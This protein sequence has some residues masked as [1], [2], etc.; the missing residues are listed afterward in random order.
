MRGRGSPLTVNGIIVFEGDVVF[1]RADS[2]Y[3]PPDLTT[4]NSLTKLK[5]DYE[6]LYTEL[7]K[8]KPG[9]CAQCCEVDLV[10]VL[11]T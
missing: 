1:Q 3:Y 4:P 7:E 6:L 10:I 11:S 5:E 9:N 2:V 8:L